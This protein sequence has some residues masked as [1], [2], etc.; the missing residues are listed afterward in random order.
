MTSR[1]LHYTIPLNLFTGSEALKNIVEND[2]WPLLPLAIL[3]FAMIPIALHTAAQA[4]RKEQQQ[5]RPRAFTAG[6]RLKPSR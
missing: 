1:L 3:I 5:S 6:N 2:S 4:R